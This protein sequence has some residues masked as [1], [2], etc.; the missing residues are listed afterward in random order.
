MFPESEKQESQDTNTYCTNCGGVIHK[1]KPVVTTKV[2]IDNK[3]LNFHVCVKCQKILNQ[4]IKDK[5]Y[6]D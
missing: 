1:G 4:M 3:V 6:H 5:M 2:K